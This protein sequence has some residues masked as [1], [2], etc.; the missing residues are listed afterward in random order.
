[1]V[2][3]VLDSEPRVQQTEVVV[4][5]GDGGDGRA[6]IRPRAALLDRDR[7]AEALDRVDLGFLHLAEELAGVRRQRLDVAPLP[8]RVQGVEREGR[9]SGSRNAGDDG[10]ALPWNLEREVLEVVLACAADRDVAQ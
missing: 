9:L 3:A 5:L 8:L 4:D 6:R 7:R 2:G 10:Q 1:A